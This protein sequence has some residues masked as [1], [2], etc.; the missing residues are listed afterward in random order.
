MRPGSAWPEPSRTR[1]ISYDAS[2]PRSVLPASYAAP[3]SYPAAPV[4]K[5]GHPISVRHLL[6]S[7]VSARLTR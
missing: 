1:Q 3:A 4:L 7:G 2:P 6:S 5:I